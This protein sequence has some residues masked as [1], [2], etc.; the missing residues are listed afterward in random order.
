MKQYIL[1]GLLS[2][3]LSTALLGQNDFKPGYIL[4]TTGDTVHGYINLRSNYLNGKECEFR[5]VLIG[6]SSFYLPGQIL[7]YRVE[8]T[9]MYVTKTVELDHKT[10]TLFMEF[11]VDGV[12]D[13]YYYKDL[14]NEYYFVEKE[15]ALYPLTNEERE[16]IRDDV[17]YRQN[18]NQYKGMLT[19]IFNDAPEIATKI[20]RTPFEYKALINLTKDYHAM[21]CGNEVCIDYTKSTYLKINLEPTIG[22]IHSSL[23][24]ETSKERSKDDQPAIGLNLRFR[25]YKIKDSWN[26][27]FGV[28]FS[29]NH[30]RKEFTSLLYV[31][32]EWLSRI[33]L[34]YQTLRIPISVEYSFPTKKIQ[35]VISL[36]FTSVF[37]M[38]REHEARYI[39]TF[40]LNGEVVQVDGGLIDTDFRKFNIAVNAGVGLKYNIDE[41]S[42]VYVTTL[43]EYRKPYVN[44][45][46]LLDYLSTTSTIWNVGYSFCINKK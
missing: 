29:K 13:L 12:I 26:V 10:Q 30:F 36:G 32:T 35:P 5:P 39:N 42:S 2:F 31:E 8:N 44:F 24:L 19:F 17:R 43:F 25:P 15:G 23:G 6:E 46:H 9:K 33:E 38:N 27:L 18:S 14:Q 41:N 22:Y 1:L 7:S 37:L 40:T 20:N 4:K 11:L 34:D 3:I 45:N 21:V 28:N 16:L